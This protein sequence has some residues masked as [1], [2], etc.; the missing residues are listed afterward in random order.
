MNCDFLEITSCAPC[1]KTARP[2]RNALGFLERLSYPLGQAGRI[3]GTL[4]DIDGQVTFA[5]C[6]ACK[7]CTLHWRAEA[8]VLELRRADHML[9][10]GRMAMQGAA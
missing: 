3:T 9:L 7:P 6:P 5:D 1:P 4:P 10:R 8:G 2:C